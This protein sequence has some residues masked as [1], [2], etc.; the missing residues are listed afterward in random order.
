[1]NSMIQRPLIES[2]RTRSIPLSHCKIKS[3]KWS[4]NSR[5]MMSSLT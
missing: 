2:L 5:N 1:M 4:C 3:Q